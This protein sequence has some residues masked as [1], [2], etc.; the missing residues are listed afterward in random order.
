MWLDIDKALRLQ[1]QLRTI[2]D[3]NKGGAQD[4]PTL[5]HIRQLCVEATETVPDGFCRDRL[6]QL[7]NLADALF[8]DRKNQP[9]ARHRKNA[10]V[11][12]LRHRAYGALD[13]LERR[14]HLVSA[15]RRDEAM[16]RGHE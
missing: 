12:S 10:G 8:S 13:E 1:Q 16:R 7:Q 14:L 3:S 6:G 5:R 11:V 2:F 4:L 9:W 15:A